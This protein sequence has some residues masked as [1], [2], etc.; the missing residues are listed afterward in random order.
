MTKRTKAAVFLVIAVLLATACEYLQKVNIIGYND[1]HY[2]YL[3]FVGGMC[4]L[5][6]ARNMEKKLWR[7]IVGL[8]GLLCVAASIVCLF[9]VV[10]ENT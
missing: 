9:L 3:D 4:L 1:Y 2:W 10:F 6:S 7:L 5:L 8:F